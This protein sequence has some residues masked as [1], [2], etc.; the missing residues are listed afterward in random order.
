MG[1][2]L[3]F[4]DV[5]KRAFLNTD[6]FGNVSIVDIMMTLMY[7][8]LLAMFIYYIYKITY[9][10]SMYSHMFNVSLVMMSLITC[11]V[12]MTISSNLVLSLGM[13]GALSIVRFRT[14]IKD[15]TDIVFMFWSIAIGISA[16]ARL[17][18]VAGVSS[19]F[20]GL[21]FFVLSKY[22][23]K[24]MTYMVIVKCSLKG[25]LEVEKILSKMDGYRLKSKRISL[26]EVEITA[27]VKMGEE[28]EDLN[29][30]YKL[31]DVIDVTAVVY[32]GNFAL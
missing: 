9:R 32:D 27:E 17:Y 4:A 6:F 21:V 22:M 15:P 20:L 24:N 31:T 13:V 2:K 11:M 16:G 12:I 25:D 7:T 1:D 18:M 28:T 14:A 8:L 10:G 3:S 5:V 26:E 23:R 29:E 30:I 19:L